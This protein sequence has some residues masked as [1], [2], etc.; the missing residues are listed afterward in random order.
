MSSNRSLVFSGLVA[1]IIAIALVS[2]A[3]YV[4]VLN[5]TTTAPIVQVSQGNGGNETVSGTSSTGIVS[6]VPQSSS[7]TTIQGS[8]QSGGLA[9]L[10]TDPPTVPDG[11]SA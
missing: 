7:S 11:V 1:A 4:G 8:G 5:T 2:G 6:S 3:V 9:V 10:M